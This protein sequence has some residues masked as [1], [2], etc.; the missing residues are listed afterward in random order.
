MFST[1]LEVRGNIND[2]VVKAFDSVI[3]LNDIFITC[4]MLLEDKSNIHVTVI[5]VS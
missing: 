2:T 4:T 3:T 5:M 1:L